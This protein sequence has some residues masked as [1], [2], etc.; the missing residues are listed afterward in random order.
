MKK[1]L[2]LLGRHMSLTSPGDVFIR[3]FIHEKSTM[4]AK[5]IYNVRKITSIFYVFL[6]ILL[7]ILFL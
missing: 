2:H 3:I 6:L 5:I 1:L 7:H 4:S